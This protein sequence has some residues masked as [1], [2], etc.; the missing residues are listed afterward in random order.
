MSSKST[1]VVFAVT[2]LLMA[3]LATA[4]S[5][6][7]NQEAENQGVCFLV[8]GTCT[9]KLCGGACAVKGSN[10]VG[11]CKGSYCCCQPKS[12]SHIGVH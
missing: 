6:A 11:S 1:L 4:V 2:W 5:S 10:G 3:L 12:P 9:Q 8:K 7:G